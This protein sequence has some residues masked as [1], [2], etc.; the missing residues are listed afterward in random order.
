MIVCLQ[1]C[2]SLFIFQADLLDCTGSSDE[3]FE[4]PPKKQG[5]IVGKSLNKVVRVQSKC[6]I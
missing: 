4:L 1:M 6:V 5:A 2:Q 3:V